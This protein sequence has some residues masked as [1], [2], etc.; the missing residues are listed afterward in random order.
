[1]TRISPKSLEVH[2]KVIILEWAS[3]NQVR[4]LKEGEASEMWAPAGQGESD[5]SV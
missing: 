4:I 3:P 1:M 5:L 2:Q